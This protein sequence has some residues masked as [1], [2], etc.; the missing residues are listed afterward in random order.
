MLNSSR[1]VGLTSTRQSD[2]TVQRGEGCSVI[3]ELIASFKA[4]KRKINVGDAWF[5]VS[6]PPPPSLSVGVLVCGPSSAFFWSGP[7]VEKFVFYIVFLFWSDQI[8]FSLFFYREG[9][10]LAEKLLL[11]ILIF[12]KFH[13]HFAMHWSYA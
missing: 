13:R 2:V 11:I 4:E 9:H 7:A 6:P 10:G 5:R 1:I 12:D 8:G 3:Y